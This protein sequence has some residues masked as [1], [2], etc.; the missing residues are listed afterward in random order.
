MKRPEDLLLLIRSLTPAEK[1]YF[2]LHAKAH[3]TDKYKNHYEKLFDAL[4]Y[5]EGD[6]DEIAFK[7]KHRAKTFTKNLPDHKQYLYDAIVDACLEQ[8]LNSSVEL[9]F[10]RGYE[11][12]TFFAQKRMM[13]LILNEYE[14]LEAIANQQHNLEK[15]I[16][17]IAKKRGAFQNS[18]KDED[19]ERYEHEIAILLE[20]YSAYN[21]LVTLIFKLRTYTEQTTTKF[22]EVEQLYQKSI[23]I[24]NRNPSFDSVQQIWQLMSQITTVYFYCKN[25]LEQAYSHILQSL[26][27]M[28]E[29]G[30]PHFD[31]PIYISSIANALQFIAPSPHRFIK[32]APTLL[33]KLKQLDFQNV[34]PRALGGGYKLYLLAIYELKYFQ[35]LKQYDQCDDVFLQFHSEY[36]KYYKQIIT[37]RDYSIVLFAY[38]LIL[39]EEAD[40]NRSLKYTEQM[41]AFIKKVHYSY[42]IAARITQLLLLIKIEEHN[43]AENAYRS[44]KKFIVEKQQEEDIFLT[45]MLQL[46]KAAVKTASLYSAEVKSANLVLQNT[47]S[48]IEIFNINIKR[49]LVEILLY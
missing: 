45:A 41:L 40:Y 24:Y 14:K 9:Q 18:L 11:R 6:Y 35:L 44:L 28:E 30:T 39:V 20:Q 23:A 26:I 29:F 16:F 43:K 48:S 13:H 1:R 34:L 21:K 49:E 8:N 33:A 27:R 15:K 17:L 4:N 2:K 36:Q 7:R 3:V 38:I 19:F 42:E 47:E 32:E 46:C 10:Y 22:D 25:D 12:T 37:V 5:W 31:T